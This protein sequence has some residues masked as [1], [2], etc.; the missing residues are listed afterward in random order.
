MKA[1]PD[2]TTV[3]PSV[4]TGLTTFLA[5]VERPLTGAAD[6]VLEIGT[7]QPSLSKKAREYNRSCVGTFT[8]YA[9]NPI[10]PFVIRR[11]GT[12][13]HAKWMGA[14]CIYLTESAALRSRDEQ[15]ALQGLEL[16]VEPLCSEVRSRYSSV[17]LV[18]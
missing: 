16:I 2:P 6:R 8:A 18:A 10:V 11:A 9:V 17:R 5:L 1:T 13:R 12:Q 3:A 7:D 14:L 4:L 15:E